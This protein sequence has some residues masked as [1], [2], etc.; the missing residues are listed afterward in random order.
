MSTNKKQPSFISTSFFHQGFTLISRSSLTF[1]ILLIILL[2]TS[3]WFKFNASH[4]GL[5]AIL[6]SLIITHFLLIAVESPRVTRFLAPIL[7][8]KPSVVY[9]RWIETDDLALTFGVYRLVWNAIDNVSLSHFGNLIFASRALCG[10]AMPDKRGD[11]NP[12]AKVLKLPFAA[13][14]LQARRDFITQLKE[15]HPQIGLSPA[16]QKMAEKPILK[17]SNYIQAFT[18]FIFLAILADVGYSTF[19][20]VELLKQYYLCEKEALPGAL[21]KAEEHYSKAEDLRTHWPI[22]SLVS[23]KLLTGSG[24]TATLQESRSKALWT[25]GKRV[26]AL[27]AQDE[28]VKLMP[29][30]FKYSLRQARLCLAL[31]KIKEAQQDIETL[32]EKHKHALL[33]RLYLTSLLW[34]IKK[35]EQAKSAL[36]DYLSMLNDEYF[37]P[38]PVWPASGEESLH[39]LFIARILIFFSRMN[40]YLLELSPPAEYVMSAR[41]R[42]LLLMKSDS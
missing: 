24:A 8:G 36:K 17:S 15:N 40:F 32:T 7:K 38:P 6:I 22:F 30:S 18:M 39:E 19:N 41:R 9:R 29:Q 42:S 23:P 14:D 20:Y 21:A 31:G 35:P 37:S 13:I 25:M 3:F 16:L 10:P 28:A 4:F 11:R 33:P 34:R 1:A 27:Q 2:S 26:E 5:L 12:A